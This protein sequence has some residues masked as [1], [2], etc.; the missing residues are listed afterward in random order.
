MCHVANEVLGCDANNVVTSARVTSKTESEASLSVKYTLRGG[1]GWVISFPCVFGSPPTS[2]NEKQ[3]L[4][5]ASASALSSRHPTQCF[6][7]PLSRPLQARKGLGC[8]S[9]S[10]LHALTHQRRPGSSTVFESNTFSSS[11]SHLAL[12][13]VLV[14]TER[15]RSNCSHYPACRL[16]LGPHVHCRAAE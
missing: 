13:A 11:S 7:A 1:P 3:S 9:W 16:P 12:T 2:H 14:L 5:S 6:R 15:R 8:S 4:V 10:S